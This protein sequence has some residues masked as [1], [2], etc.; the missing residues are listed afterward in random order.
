M[1]YDFKTMGFSLDL[2]R[3]FTTGDKEYN[4]FV[5]WQFHKYRDAGYLTQASYPIL[6]CTTDKNAVGEDDIQEAD[7]EPVD[8]Q[9]FTA[10]KF[11]LKEEKNGNVNSKANEK[12]NSKAF[13]VSATLRPDTIYGVTNIFVKPTLTY[14]RVTLTKDGKTEEWIVAKKAVEKLELQGWKARISQEFPGAELIGKEVE[15]PVG[16]KVPVL[17]AEFVEE[18]AG[19]GVVHSVPAHAPFDLVAIE[20]L[21]TSAAVLEKYPGLADKVK[22][23]KML[24]VLATPGYSEIP[25]LDLVK[26]ANIKNTRQADLLKKVTYQLYKDE[27]YSAKTINSGKFNGLTDEVAKEKLG[28]W[29]RDENKATDFFET[30]RPALCRCGGGVMAAVLPDQWFLDFKAKGWKEKANACLQGMKIHPENYRKQF[31]D[32]FAWLDKRPCARRRGLGTQLPFANEWIIE[33]L[34][35][36]TIYPAFYTVIKPVREHKLKPEQLTPEF[37]DFVFLGKGDA[38]AIA[39]KIGTKKEIL[40]KIRTEFT[41]W[42][43]CDQRHTAIA[44]I[45]NHLSFYIFAHTAIFPK[46]FW[47]KSITV[48]ELLISE[49]T[50]M[51]KSKGNVVTLD[52]VRQNYFADLYRVYSVTTADFASVLDFRKKDIENNRKNLSK[53]FDV[54]ER[55]I[56]LAKKRG[57]KA[58]SGMAK[59]IISKFESRLKFCTQALEELKLRDYA[60]AAVFAM[61]RDWEYFCHRSSEVEQA[62]A[63]QHIIPKWILL[64][65]PL[66]PH[67]S[68]ELWEKLGKKNFASLAQW[69]KVSE[70]LID[71]AAEKK[72]D[73]LQYVV[74]DVRKVREL[75]ERKGTKPTQ[76]LLVVASENKWKQLHSALKEKTKDKALAAVENESVKKLIDRDY[77]ALAAQGVEKMDEIAALR[78]AKEFLEKSLGLKVEIETEE[79]SKSEKAQRAVPGKPSI[80]LS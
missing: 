3:Q 8:V 70:K 37:F 50:K 23:I 66:A 72:E 30:S 22:K 11:K 58:N 16:N 1:I 15:T 49:G 54:L 69:P 52:Y 59:W 2:S 6:Y 39:K 17:P 26:K 14:A 61:L 60:Q 25:A 20:E 71:S 67:I 62:K 38:A 75:V 56:E 19:T 55:G 9:R 78:E 29:L 73:F 79:K 4:K 76:V 64:L 48:N 18:E 12:N 27:F 77:Y 57:A 80:M 28:Q 33:S 74:E 36:S 47:P 43:P 21:K 7:T 13:L 31:V 42:Y 5:E 53:L 65:S 45:N 32:T 51:S 35:D 10:V 34:S 46:K 41:Y 24:P 68:E 40:E 44:H 63:S